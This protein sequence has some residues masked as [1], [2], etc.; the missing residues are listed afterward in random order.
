MPVGICGRCLVIG[1]APA[2]HEEGRGHIWIE[3]PF[4]FAG[5][6]VDGVNDV[7]I[8]AGIDGV[9]GKDRGVLVRIGVEPLLAGMVGP[10]DLQVCHRI[11]VDLIRRLEPVPQRAAAVIAP[12]ACHFCGG[13]HLSGAG[14]GSEIVADHAV[15]QEHAVNGQPQPDQNQQRPKPRCPDL[16]G[17]SPDRRK[18]RDR[19]QD[20]EQREG[21]GEQARDQRPEPLIHAPDFHQRPKGGQREDDQIQQHAAHFAAQDQPARKGGRDAGNCIVPTA[22]KCDQVDA[23]QGQRQ[24]EQDADD[25]QNFQPDTD[26]VSIELNGNNPLTSR[27][28][29]SITTNI[30]ARA[31][32][33]RHRNHGN[34]NKSYMGCIDLVQSARGA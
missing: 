28:T 11:T 25:A 7:V 20:K 17:F 33:D 23:G 34:I 19:Q 9:F 16:S 6:T 24:P 2:A 14:C 31:R 5:F 26:V 15:G 21:E 3:D 22:A 32:Y 8:G 30:P 18:Q 13:R 12:L 4:A 29:K 1:H 27:I 10:G